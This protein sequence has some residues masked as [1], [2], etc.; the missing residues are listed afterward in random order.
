MQEA[1]DR[2]GLMQEARD[3]LGLMPGQAGVITGGDRLV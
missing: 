1:R 2:L 3:R